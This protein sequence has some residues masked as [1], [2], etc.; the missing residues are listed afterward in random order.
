MGNKITLAI[1]VA[2]IAIASIF[3][4]STI[5]QARF[6]DLS[7][8]GLVVF[9]LLYVG[10]L[11]RYTWQIV[12]LLTWS[13]VRLNYGFLLNS[14]HYAV[15]LLLLYGILIVLFRKN[16]YKSPALFEAQKVSHFAFVIGIWV[17]FGV[18]SFFANK[19]SPFSGGDYS[20]K[21]MLKGYFDGFGPCLLLFVALVT[22]YS[23]RVGKNVIPVI[24]GIL[25]VSAFLNITHLFYMYIQGYGFEGGAGPAEEPVSLFYIPII[26]A[27]LGV[28]TMRGVG[29]VA[30]M[31]S[32]SFLCQSGWLKSQSIK[33][34]LT[35]FG[36]FGMGL[37]GCVIS[38]GRASLLLALLYIGIIS[39]LNR[40]LLMI[41]VATC[42]GAS[43]VLLTNV[44]S[45]FINKELPVYVARPL[46]YV[47]IEKGNAMNSIEHS[48]SYR[49][50]LYSAALEEWSSHPRIMSIGRSVYVPID[51]N[52]LKGVVGDK[53]SFVMVNLNSGTCHALLPSALVQYGILGAL[54]YYLV[55]FMLIRLFWKTYKRA[56]NGFYSE[57]LKMI[58]LLMT[59]STGIGVVVATV[60]GGWFGA[61]EIL[62]V[63]LVKSM[64]ARDE[65]A[66][67]KS[68]VAK[69]STTQTLEVPAW[70]S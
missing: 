21:N 58:S 61:L 1:L 60:G 33:T 7:L 15:A 29:P 26:N 35:T 38:G 43:I 10:F 39:L 19:I 40:R 68:Q 5:G 70:S 49:E 66:Y 18:L 34:K 3:L 51:Y 31:F 44:F 55:Y 46:Q 59:F 11:Y 32:Y 22:S 41:A 50:E 63:V 30:V 67:Q 65:L 17:M 52:D 48:S 24:L 36:V 14:V 54:L 13:G 6:V 25:F 56:K 27:S 28:F 20:T 12:L 16:P 4:G 64:A 2:V 37:L 45:G 69:E 47:M 53:A 57:D 42:C 8:Y 62:M 9:V 23:F